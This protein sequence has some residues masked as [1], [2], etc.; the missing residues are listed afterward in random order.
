MRL[1]LRVL[2]YL[3][4]YRALAAAALACA[5][6]ATVV[7]LIPPWVIKL[8]I[9]TVVRPG[10]LGPLPWLIAGLALAYLGRN[11]LTAARVRFNNV[12]EQRVIYDLRQAV[13]DKL[14]AL[15]VRYYDQRATGELVSRV[16]SDVT[17]LERILI[18]GVESLVMA[19]LTLAGLTVM[20]F[21]MHWQL[22]LL[23]LIHIPFLAAGAA[24]FTRRVHA[25]Y[26]A[27]R[28]ESG[29]LN[30][31]LQDQLSG[32]REI[33][34]FNRE[35][36]AA[37]RFDVHS[38]AYCRE[39][40]RVAR[41]WS[42]Y[43]PSMVFVGSLGT[44]LILGV[45]AREVVA[46]RMTLGELVAFLSY[47]AMFYV[48]IN[49]IHSVNHMLQHALASGERVFEILDAKPEVVAAVGAVTLPRGAG[50]VR[51]EKVSFGY[52]PDAEVIHRVDLTLSPGDKVALVGPSGAGKSTLVKLLLRFYDA[53]S[54][55]IVIDGR[56]IRQVTLASLRDQIGLVPQDPVLFNGTVRENLLFGRPDAK[57]G[58][59]E[60]S[61][62][63]ARAH[64]FIAAM[65]EG[66]DT[67]VGERGVKLSG[68]QKQRLAIARALLKDPPIVVLDEATSNIDSETE[69]QIQAAL[70]RLIAGRTTLIIAHRLSTLRSV[71]RIIVLDHGR[72]VET[73]PHDDL[74]RRGGLY[75]ALYDAQFQV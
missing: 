30:A 8:I 44:V 70:E 51:F 28:Q 73:G 15:S 43:S 14:Q 24:V 46:G 58:D 26:R 66:Y 5:V 67:L 10:D 4:P 9:D 20:L 18:D 42:L 72:I 49:Q 69:V 21:V 52:R 2:T 6:L 62:H 50:E 55:R 27:I 12:L 19:G 39:Q 60:A 11:V 56:D 35:T 54:G 25:L 40:L 64:E 33:F 31:V 1:L 36:Y 3:A 53:G 23:A 74:L 29:R 59:L 38:R 7:D 68:G 61:A 48:P 34:A 57:D 16:T 17:N 22:A 63:A 45:G 75:A 37:E 71:D 47:L 32:I 65:P 41:V 13:Y